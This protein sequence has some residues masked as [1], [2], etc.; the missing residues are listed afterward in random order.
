MTL[1]FVIPRSIA[2]RNPQPPTDSST[3][4]RCAQND[5]S[6]EKVIIVNFLHHRRTDGGRGEKWLKNQ[7]FSGKFPENLLTFPKKCL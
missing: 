2:T 3:P 6:F 4:L 7:R 1:P 5:S